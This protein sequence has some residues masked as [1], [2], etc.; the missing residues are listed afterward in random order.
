MKIY[1]FTISLVASSVVLAGEPDP[2]AGSYWLGYSTNQLNM[3]AVTLGTAVDKAPTVAIET[4]ANLM[5]GLLSELPKEKQ[6][7]IGANLMK[8]ALLEMNPQERQQIA[9]D[10]TKG[11]LEAG[12]AVAGAGLVAAKDVIIAKTVETA[13]S[14]KAAT[15]AGATVS[16][17]YVAGAAAVGVVGYGSYWV[18]NDF[19]RFMK[20]LEEYDQCLNQHINCPDLNARGFPKRCDSPA[21]KVS[22]YGCALNTKES[23]FKSARAKLQEAKVK[24]EVI[25]K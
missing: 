10:L 5:K 17:P 7:E 18:Y 22:H 15:I 6:L 3:A 19:R 11:A 21:R 25:Y 24:R 13:V 20:P 14:A 23:N 12:V 9:F 2:K 4:G 1:I 8:G 16:A